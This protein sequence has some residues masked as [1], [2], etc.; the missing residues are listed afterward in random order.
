MALNNPSPQDVLS[1]LQ[2]QLACSNELYDSE[3]IVRYGAFVGSNIES[4]DFL[5]R[6]MIYARTKIESLSASGKSVDSG[7]VILADTMSHSKGRFSREWHA[8]AGGVW[9]CMIHAS[10]L[11]PQSRCFVPLAVGVACCEAVRE[12]GGNMAVLRWVNDVL[13]EGKKLAGFLVETYTE[14]FYGEEYNLVGFGVNINNS[15]FP[16]ELSHTAVSLGEVLDTAVNLTQ[17]T[18]LFLA[19]LAWN[20]G[21]LYYEESCALRDEGF[22]GQGGNHLLLDQWRR[23]SDTVGKR[24][25]Y[26]FDVMNS[27][28]YKATVLRMDENGGLVLRLEDGFEKTE[29]SGEVR[30]L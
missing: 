11:L 4:H 1:H 6:A 23:L 26:G 3:A 12:M 5:D 21:L 22:S 15:H 2:Q 28:Q 16:G 14:S 10:T 7:T 25:V 18:S 9:G 30:Y 29:Y 24:V 13:V 8:P 17:F 27:P 19:R 20:F